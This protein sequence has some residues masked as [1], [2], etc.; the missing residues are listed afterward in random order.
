M[1]LLTNEQQELYENVKMCYICERKFDNK[2]TSDK[3]YWKVKDHCHYIGEYRG[4][5][6]SICNLKYSTPKEITVIFHNGSN[7]DYHFITKESA[8][9]FEK[10]L[11]STQLIF[12]TNTI[13]KQ[14]VN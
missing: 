5:T 11:F 8:E 9:E 1:K 13:L 7:Y 4:A 14:K 2:Y 12:N 3:K 10:H 6:Y